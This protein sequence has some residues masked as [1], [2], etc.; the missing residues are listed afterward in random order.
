MP[1]LKQAFA[2]ARSANPKA[3]LALNDYD[4]TPK[5][6][7]L[8][9]DGL[10]AGADIDVLGIQS[11]MHYGYWGE[12]TIWETC[13]RFAKFGR[14]LHWTEVTILAGPRREKLDY[15]KRYD[16]WLSTSEGEKQQAEQVEQFYT[17][18]FSHP[19]VAAITWWDL[20]DLDAWL[21]APAGLLRK[22]MTPRPA[23]EA[24]MKLVKGRWWTGEVR[25]RTDGAGQVHFRGFLG[26]YVVQ[27]PTGTATFRLERPGEVRLTSQVAAP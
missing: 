8:I 7:G 21:G 5:Y 4:T 17:L 13:E 20:S 14:P 19:A 22:D 27:T 10:A 18:L 11:H 23:Y 16:D 6:E 26:S 25:A 24:L 9:R 1:L 3:V 2:T 15:S 12:K